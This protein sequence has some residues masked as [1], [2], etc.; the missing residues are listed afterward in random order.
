[1]PTPHRTAVYKCIVAVESFP[2]ASG[3]PRKRSRRL[4]F[5]AWPYIDDPNQPC[6]LPTLMRAVYFVTHSTYLDLKEV[7]K[8][9]GEYLARQEHIDPEVRENALALVKA[10]QERL[11]RIAKINRRLPKEARLAEPSVFFEPWNVNV[12]KDI[13]EGLGQVMELFIQALIHGNREHFSGHNDAFSFGHEH[14][15]WIAKAFASGKELEELA[16]DSHITL[17]MLAMFEEL[18]AEEID[19]LWIRFEKIREHIDD[20]VQR[21]EPIE[22]IFATYVGLQFLP[23]DTRNSVAPLVQQWLRKRNWNK[24]YEDFAELCDD[25]FGPIAMASL[26]CEPACLVLLNIDMDGIELLRSFVKIYKIILS[27]LEII[28]EHVEHT[29]PN[30][31]DRLLGEEILNLLIFAET[32][33][34]KKI[35]RILEDEHIPREIYWW[36]SQRVWAS[37]KEQEMHIIEAIRNNDL[38]DLGRRLYGC[39]PKITLF[40]S[41]ASNYVTSSISCCEHVNVVTDTENLSTFSRMFYESLAQQILKYQRDKGS[42][43]CPFSSKKCCGRRVI[44]ERLYERLPEKCRKNITLP[45]CVRER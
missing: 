40:G 18:S 2:A 45:N 31:L 35:N 8:R 21:F 34:A 41:L 10:H 27:T 39:A 5:P 26:L 22:E 15:H 14:A 17:E 32:Q 43:V 29:D 38:A 42:L 6:C 24:V 44:L 9:A 19:E 13:S 28:V 1:M 33:A 36:A 4:P 37:R 3:Q 20:L 12:M 11:Y 25:G 16:H 23:V 7:E 30:A